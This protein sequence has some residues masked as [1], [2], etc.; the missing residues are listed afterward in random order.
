[1]IFNFTK[2][3]TILSKLNRSIIGWFCTAQNTSCGD[4]AHDRKNQENQA[5]G[6]F[7]LLV[8]GDASNRH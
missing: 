4:I 3:I 1:M 8:S 6:M 5:G 7:G 2:V